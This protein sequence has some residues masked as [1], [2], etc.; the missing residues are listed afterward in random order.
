MTEIKILWLINDLKWKFNFLV[1][2]SFRSKW[3]CSS[4]K[5]QG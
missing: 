5:F 2:V 4:G 3:K 1:L